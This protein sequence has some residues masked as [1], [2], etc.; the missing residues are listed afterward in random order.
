MKRDMDLIR[1][2][3][4]E[5]EKLPAMQMWNSRPLLEHDDREVFAHVK[6]AE[7]AGLLIASYAT[8]YSAMVQRLTNAGYDFLEASKIPTLWQRAKDQITA[9]AL[10]I[11]AT[12]L[13]AA[14]QTLISQGLSKLV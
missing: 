2:I 9:A 11:T 4:I 5:V 12:T 7:E 6:L 14:L 3:L 8:G 10:P 13:K 1:E